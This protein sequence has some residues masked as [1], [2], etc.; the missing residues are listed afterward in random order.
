MHRSPRAHHA[1]AWVIF[2]LFGV[3]S[4]ADAGQNAAPLPSQ[5]S[6][7]APL[8]LPFPFDGAPPP[9]PPQVI[10][11]DA[12]GRVTVRAVRL[13]API[14]IDGQLDEDVYAE[15][16]P[17]SDFIQTDPLEGAPASQQTEVWLF[18]DREN[19]Y[20]VGR[21]WE[22]HLDRM[23]ANEMR[24]DTGIPQNDNFAWSFDTFYDRRNGILFEVTPVGGRL[25]AQ[26]T[27]ERQINS[28]W[29]P[30]WE[31]AVGRFDGGWTVEAALPFRSLRYR[32]G[33]AQIWGFQARR[34]NLWKNEVSYLTPI[35][36]AIGTQGHFRSSLSATLVGLEAPTNLKNL[37][38]KPY[39]T[40]HLTSDARTTPP[41]SN[42]LGGDIGGDVKYGI[43]QN[44]TADFTVNTDFAQVEADEQQVNLTRF[45]LFFPEKREFFLENQGTFAFGGAGTSG[46]QASRADTPVLFYSR[47]I[48]LN[49]GR[50]VPV[51]G[52]GR[53]TGRVAAFNLGLLSIQDDG[54]STSGAQPTNFSVVRVK[55]DLLRRSSVGAMF[56]NRSVSQQGP[57]TNQAYGID[58]A[59]SFFNDLT[60]NT[61]WARTH[62]EGFSDDDVS[63]RAQ[64]DYAGDRYGVELDH[65]RVGDNFNPEVGFVRRDDMRRSFGLL[66]FSPRPQS[67]ES[68]RK[69]SWTGSMSY[70]ENGTG[71]VE[72]R[73]GDGE[74]GVELENS[75]QFRLGYTERY[76]FLPRPFPIA[77]DVTLPVG[78]Y[79]FGTARV[80]YDLGRQRWISGNV[81]AEHGT[82]FSGHKTSLGLSQGRVNVTPQVSVEPA[83]S[84]NWVDLQEGSFT[85][86]LAGSR[87]IY[88]M[89]PLVFTSA[90]LQYNSGSNAM[91]AN[92]RLRWEYQP[93]SELF[94]VYTEQRD[95]TARRFPEMTNRAFII[96]INRL[97]RF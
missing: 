64:L 50:E 13:T 54:A 91:T 81:L 52:G 24:R 21:C 15:I 82:F 55:R 22:A 73:E 84:I 39:V 49:E 88:T 4:A 11:R 80:G 87:I 14:R 44:L 28:D 40:S 85:T 7:T 79:S 33:R 78:S 94:V 51:R 16:S 18:F 89:T 6:P 93:G 74:F 71:Q 5:T 63:Y 31:V 29:N 92:V 45:S 67:L 8:D 46:P 17:M 95:T 53:L 65:L 61:Y 48:G 66:R 70:V 96:K 77:P 72:T 34:K 75:D 59:F 56:T 83:Y 25:D 1:P 30:V 32:P 86:H 26:V 69:F 10:S 37:E 76:E 58:G 12:A 60:I 27:N 57:G 20:V 36:A 41:V 68:I 9:V 23:V 62:T 47:R 90:L 97:F 19:V 38:I 42:S 43:T 35:P 3:F 2:C